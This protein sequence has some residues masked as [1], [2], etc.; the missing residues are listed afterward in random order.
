M[1]KRPG[2]EKRTERG[3]QRRWV[4]REG[5]AGKEVT[6]SMEKDPMLKSSV[7]S[8]YRPRSKENQGKKEEKRAPQW[9]GE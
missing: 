4:D 2:R 1:K 6:E 3:R 7:P 9:N 5:P 8:G